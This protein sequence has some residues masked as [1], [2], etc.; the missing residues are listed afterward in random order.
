MSERNKNHVEKTIGVTDENQISLPVKSE[1]VLKA[2]YSIDE[3][4]RIMAYLRSDEGCP[5]DREQNHKSLQRNMIE[6]AYEAVDAIDSGVP[7]RLCDELGDV[8]MQVVFHAQIADENNQFTFDDVISKICYKLISRHSHIFAD[9]QAADAAAVLETWERNKKIEKGHKTQTQVL[10]DVPISLPALHRS[11]KIQQKA[12]QAG[13]DWD[14][15]DGPKTKIYEELDE[16]EEARRH[17]AALS[18]KI[19]QAEDSLGDINQSVDKN[20]YTEDMSNIYDDQQIKEAEQPAGQRQ[21]LDPEADS[22]LIAARLK[23]TDEVGDLLFAVVNYARHV[24]VQPEI[25]LNRTSSRFIRRFSEVEMLAAEKEQEMASMTLKE[26]D[27]LWDE[28]KRRE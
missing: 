18:V 20:E 3:L 15:I 8:L 24:G 11:Y 25:A 7:E 14:N 23:L 19:S 9:D 21:I 4:R 5:W 13:F 6:E 12:A 26:L 1:F 28:A 2:R 16:A 22:E 10:Q 17:L 27:L